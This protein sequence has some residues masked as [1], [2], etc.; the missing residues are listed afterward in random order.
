MSH[1]TSFF[2]RLT[3]TILTI[4]NHIVKGICY[5]FYKVVYLFYQ[6]YN[7]LYCSYRTIL[8]KAVTILTFQSKYSSKGGHLNSIRSCC[9]LVTVAFLTTLPRYTT[10]LSQASESSESSSCFSIAYLARTDNLQVG[11]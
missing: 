6:G 5:K 4:R 9:L 8:V 1:F 2:V 7:H 3:R 11:E 10:I